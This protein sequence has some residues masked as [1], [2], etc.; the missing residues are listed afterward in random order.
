MANGKNNSF[1]GSSGI[2]FWFILCTISL[3]PNMDYIYFP[4]EI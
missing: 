4:N 2:D 1:N 3:E